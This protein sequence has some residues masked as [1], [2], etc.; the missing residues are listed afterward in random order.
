MVFHL[1]RSCADQYL[2]LLYGQMKE[3]FLKS[4][5]IH[6]DET[7]MQVIDEPDQKG[8]SQNWMWVYLTDRYSEAPQMVLFDYERTRGGY[9][10][11]NFPWRHISW[12]SDLRW[13]SGISW[14]ERFHYRN[15]VLYPCQT[16]L[17]CRTYGIKKGFQ[18][19]GVS[20]TM[21]F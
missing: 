7:R 5:Y 19:Q 14:T 3:E 2:G 1:L 6:C 13:I 11:V 8:S 21:K 4:R 18:K 10:P 20:D 16:S 15:R 9:H 12:I 17:R